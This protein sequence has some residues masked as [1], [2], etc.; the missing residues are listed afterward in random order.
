M[1]FTLGAWLANDRVI[2]IDLQQLRRVP[3]AIGVAGGS[4]KTAAIRAALLGG[5]IN[6]LITD[7]LTAQRLLDR[8]SAQG[9]VSADLVGTD[10]A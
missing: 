10:V 4:R 3:R 8:G 5:W 2:G 6:C 1:R 9:K 7:R